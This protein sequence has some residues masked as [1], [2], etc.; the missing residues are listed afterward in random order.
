[1]GPLKRWPRAHLILALSSGPSV[2]SR[3]Y[4]YSTPAGSPHVWRRRCPCMPSTGGSNYAEVIPG[5]ISTEKLCEHF[6]WRPESEHSRGPVIHLVGH[7]LKVMNVTGDLGA[8]REILPDYPVGVLVGS[9]S[10]G[11]CVCAK[12]TG[13]SVARVRVVCSLPAVP[14]DLPRP[15]RR[16]PADRG[17]YVLL[18]HMQRGNGRFLPVSQCKR[19]RRTLPPIHSR[20]RQ[21]SHSGEILH[22]EIPYVA[23][24]KTV[25][26]T[27]LPRPAAIK[28]SL[29]AAPACVAADG[30]RD[31]SARLLRGARGGP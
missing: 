25:R 15:H 9:R 17:G 19:S 26:Y 20:V 28:L 10:H 31:Q 6:C 5:I 13:I 23:Y 4:R 8:F 21:A 14:G 1:M 29:P 30:R 2:E 22:T 16:V 3:M 27:P 7:G 11:E 24:E 18:L 12:C